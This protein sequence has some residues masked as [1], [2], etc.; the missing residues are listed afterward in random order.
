M[1]STFGISHRPRRRTTLHGPREAP[2]NYTAGSI[3]AEKHV[4][5]RTATRECGRPDGCIWV[6]PEHGLGVVVIDEARM[7][8]VSWRSS[9]SYTL[10]LV[11][12]CDMFQ[13][14]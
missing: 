9:L 7:R 2:H 14:K 10:T 8:P 4:S 6:V 12:A 1:R 11:I 5:T 3:A 13:G